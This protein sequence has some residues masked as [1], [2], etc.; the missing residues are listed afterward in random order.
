LKEFQEIITNDGSLTLQSFQFKE[1]FHSHEGALKETKT[2]F[3]DPAKIERFR[4][5]SINVLDVCFG[6]G[7]NSA[8]L[9]N[10]L[11]NQSSFLNW[12]ALEIDKRPLD[13]AIKKNLFKNLWGP[14]IIRIFK[15]LF[16][17]GHFSDKYFNCKMLWGD[18]RKEINKI[19]ESTKFDLI[20][21]DG[22]SPQ[23]CPEV[24]S[25][26]FLTKLKN[27]LKFQGYLITYSSSAAVRKTLITIGLK[28]YKIKP[29]L[30]TSKI[31]SNGT[32]AIL[33]DNNDTENNNSY[34][35]KLTLKEYEHLETKAS[36]PYRD[37]KCDS[38]SQEIIKRREKEQFLSKLLQTNLWRKKWQMTKSTFKG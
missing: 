4:N 23:K 10:I 25:I 16:K 20:F 9:F 38:L 15:S 30:E 26:E 12:Y 28:V 2:K 31:W 1:S 33:D 32:L 18:A 3:I 27:K 21:L 29:K 22:F 34:I 37:P 13:Y 19:P 7:Y 8:Y 24:W 36:I 17:V 35:E 11:L 14:K 6:L 5:K